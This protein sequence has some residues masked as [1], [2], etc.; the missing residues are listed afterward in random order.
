MS[1]VT[2]IIDGVGTLVTGVSMVV[3]PSFEYEFFTCISCKLRDSHCLGMGFL[4]TIFLMP[5]AARDYETYQR[6]GRAEDELERV[7]KK[8][9]GREARWNVL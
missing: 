7:V 8:G 4:A 3:I 2:G 6:M 9:K 1:T 5:L